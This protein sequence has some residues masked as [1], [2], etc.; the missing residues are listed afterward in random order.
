[1]EMTR[2]DIAPYAL[3]HAPAGE[4]TFE[5]SRGMGKK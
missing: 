4:L 5:E 1:M 2:F 3:P